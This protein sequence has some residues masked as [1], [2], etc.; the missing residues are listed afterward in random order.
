MAKSIS[1]QI[2]FERKKDKD[3]NEKGKDKPKPFPK[4]A[5][6]RY[7]DIYKKKYTNK[8]KFMGF[9][10]VDKLRKLLD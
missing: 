3:K 2:N 10:V 1:E 5:P 6:K 8:D 9:T 4:D 7:H